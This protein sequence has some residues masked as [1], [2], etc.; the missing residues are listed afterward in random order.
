MGKYKRKG[1]RV[2]YENFGGGMKQGRVYSGELKA[3]VLIQLIERLPER[4]LLSW[5]LSRLDFPS[6]IE[7]RDCGCAFNSSIE[8]RWEKLTEERYCVWILSD[9]ELKDLP[10]DL[11][12]IEGEW[13]IEEKTIQLINLNDRRFAPQFEVYPVVNTQEARLICRVFYRNKI[14]IF[15]SPREVISNAQE[16]ER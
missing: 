14:A 7:L 1:D 15:I 3:E 2:P 5:N 16:S 8:I 9:V 13:K 10:E 4:V 11:R 12:P 6:N